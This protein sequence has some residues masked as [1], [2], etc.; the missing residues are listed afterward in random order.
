MKRCNKCGVVKPLSDFY[1]MPEMRDGNR[2]DCKRCNLAAKAARYRANP[3][4][5]IARAK[6]WRE[7]NPERARATKAAYIEAGRKRA[8]DRRYQLKRKYGITPEQYD[9]LLAEQSGGCAICGRPPRRDISLHV[10]HE[11]GTGRIRGLL[12]FRCNNAL[13]DFGDDHDRLG[14]ALAYLGTVPKD[15]ATVARL[16]GLLHRT[17]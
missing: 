8:V 5:D 7:S 9:A 16:E 14:A 4:P 15:A 10:D 6:A 1:R 11:H 17:A 13:G 3:G 12:C 2:N